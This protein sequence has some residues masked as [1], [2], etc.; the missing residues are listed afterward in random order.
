MDVDAIALGADYVNVMGVEIAKCDVLLAVIGP[1][2]IDARDEAGRRRLDSEQDYVRIEIAAA[3]HRGIPVIPILLEGTRV[4][5]LEQ[6]PDDLKSLT[7]RNALNVRHVSFHADMDKLVSSLRGGAAAQAPG[8]I[9]IDAK[10]S[11]GAPDGMFR[12]GLGRTEWFKDYDN[13]SIDSGPEMVLIPPGT[14][15]MGSPENEPER[16]GNEGPQHKVTIGHMFAVARHGVTRKQF[17]AFIES[18][19]YK[20]QVGSQVFDHETAKWKFDRKLTWDN[21]G[22]RQDDNHP[23]V[24]VSW[25]DAKAYV[26]WLTKVTGKAYRLLNEAEREYVARAGTTTPFWWGSAISPSQ[27]NYNPSYGPYKGGGSKGEFREKTVPVR[28]FAA[29][30]WGLFEVHGNVYE[31]CEDV[32][33]DNYAG[34]PTDGSAWLADSPPRADPRRRVIRGGSWSDM[35]QFLRSANRSTRSV[36]LLDP[37]IGFRVARTLNP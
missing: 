12:P 23:V 5:K 16:Q 3:L 19:G 37:T 28:N 10:K 25:N 24:C 6:L 4:P 35:P 26:A 33:H 7:Q 2:W 17:A 11:F 14:F 36:D 18:S 31:W 15:I 29:N 9:K 13:W 32:W 22:I 21:T 8:R 1:N 27:A 20:A 34:A 30:P